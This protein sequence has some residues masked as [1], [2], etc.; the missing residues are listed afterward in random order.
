M[1]IFNDVDLEELAPVKIDDIHVSPISLNVVAQQRSIQ[2]GQDYVRTVGSNKTVTITFALLEQDINARYQTILSIVDWARVGEEHSLRLPMMDGYHLDVICVE[3]PSP[4]YRMWWEDNLRLV[5]HT[6]DNPYWTSDNENSADF[7]RD[8]NIGGNAPPLMRIERTLGTA[9][10]NRSYSN[11]TESMLYTT[12]PAGRLVIDLNKQ[13]STV[14]GSN[15]DRYLSPTS[16]YIIPRTGSQNLR[17]QG[18]IYY[19]ERVM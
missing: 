16:T 14:S 15:I 4:S 19:R 3:V 7:G 13:I 8:I 1:I 12:I 5:F 9:E 18:T 17:G 2:W 11:G 6:M 10:A